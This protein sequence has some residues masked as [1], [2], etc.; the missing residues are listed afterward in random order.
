MIGTG[1]PRGLRKEDMSVQARM[2][3]IADIFEALTASD[4]PYKPAKK[5]SVALDILGGFK[6]RNHIDPDLFDVFIQEE[7]YME[8]AKEFMATHLIDNVN[9]EAL[10]GIKPDPV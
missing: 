1:Y 10:V 2:M 8:Y 5:L 4:R 6:K 7:V 9:K 3:A